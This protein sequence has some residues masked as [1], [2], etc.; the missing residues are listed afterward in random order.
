MARHSLQDCPHS[1]HGAGVCTCRHAESS[2]EMRG[3][4]PNERIVC[5]TCERRGEP[6]AEHI[7]YP[8]AEW[9][10]DQLPEN[11]RNED[12]S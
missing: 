1:Y 5:V 11:N 6:D 7:Y 10:W 8:L 4:Y 12:E 9:R 3:N 2:H